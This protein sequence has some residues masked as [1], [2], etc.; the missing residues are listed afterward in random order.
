MKWLEYL[1]TVEH[2]KTIKDMKALI[3]IAVCLVLA[4]V[5]RAFEFFSTR[6]I[7][8]VGAKSNRSSGDI[9]RFD[10]N[11]EKSLKEALDYYK[12]LVD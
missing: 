9:A 10:I 12:D 8:S 6:K 5:F 3:I 7:N 4:V 11:D 2:S 1:C